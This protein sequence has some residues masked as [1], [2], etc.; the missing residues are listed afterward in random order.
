MNLIAGNY[1]SKMEETL[2]ILSFSDNNTNIH[3]S[4]RNESF[5]EVGNYDA[6]GLSVVAD[7][8]PVEHTRQS[9]I[10]NAQNDDNNKLQT[11]LNHVLKQLS[12]KMCKEYLLPVAYTE[13]ESVKE[14]ERSLN[15]EKSNSNTVLYAKFK[16]DDYPSSEPRY[17]KIVQQFDVKN[18][19][20]PTKA[21]EKYQYKDF[22]Y[23]ISKINGKNLEYILNDRCT[24]SHGNQLYANT[25]S[26][27]RSFCMQNGKKVASTQVAYQ[28]KCCKTSELLSSSACSCSSKYEPERNGKLTTRRPEVDLYKLMA[29][30]TND[31]TDI[32]EKLEHFS[33]NDIPLLMDFFKLQKETTDSQSNQKDS[34]G[35]SDNLSSVNNDLCS[36][37]TSLGFLE[38]ASHQSLPRII[39][40]SVYT[41]IMWKSLMKLL[42]HLTNEERL[43]W[44]EQLLSTSKF[45]YSK[46]ETIDI[47]S[48]ISDVDHFHSEELLLL[49][50]QVYE[51][52]V[53]RDYLQYFS[54]ET[55]KVFIN[56]NLVIKEL[57]SIIEKVHCDT[58]P[59][60]PH[61]DIGDE[62][63]NFKNFS[64]PKDYLKQSLAVHQQ[65]QE[66][67]ACF[68]MFNN[69]LGISKKWSHSCGSLSK[70][71]NNPQ[72]SN[73]QYTECN[74]NRINFRQ[75]RE[76]LKL[77]HQQLLE[78][79]YHVTEMVGVALDTDMED[80]INGVHLYS[81]NNHKNGATNYVG[82]GL[83]KNDMF[84]N[85][86]TPG[87]QVVAKLLSAMLD[88]ETRLDTISENQIVAE[89][90]TNSDITFNPDLCA[91]DDRRRT[92]H[93]SF[94]ETTPSSMKSELSDLHVNDIQRRQHIKMTEDISKTKRYK[95]ECGRSSVVNEK[96]HKD[97]FKEEK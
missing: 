50:R 48:L 2:N 85:P 42:N 28:L 70:I 87:L 21:F 18:N 49:W 41:S 24:E 68:S 74:T 14:L 4:L 67:E 57:L 55:R 33:L 56:L 76:L 8:N 75:M 82:N 15:I 38:S 69:A 78:Q 71:Q 9:E 88:L 25:F 79:I 89:N 7:E 29:N 20:K 84:T 22:G 36:F 6:N 44:H 97:N 59:S 10:N 90:I 17:S 95:T 94:Q 77:S 30:N 81:V 5:N 31:P 27:K 91:R 54:D 66:N 39:N 23:G 60:H 65:H 3:D 47:K 12:R 40:D 73:N 26:T 52:W 96:D 1:G 93:L 53:P 43:F 61:I 34:A 86:S 51:N 83:T 19:Y 72:P 62:V 35:E 64:T 63:D 13:L 37:E 80:A 58:S 45:N 92:P 46:A 11:N 16:G 32:L